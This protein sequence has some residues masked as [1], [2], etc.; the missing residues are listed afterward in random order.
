MNTLILIHLQIKFSCTE[1]EG[2]EQRWI[3][4]YIFLNDYCIIHSYERAHWENKDEVREG[5]NLVLC[6]LTEPCS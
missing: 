5:G 1:E 6:I 3:H 2:E 4:I